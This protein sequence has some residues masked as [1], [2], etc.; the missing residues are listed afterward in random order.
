LRKLRKN[1]GMTGADVAKAL[2]ISGS[3]IS[4]VETSE[5]GIYLDDIE[6]LLD[7]YN[8]TRA[9]R[10]ELLDLARHA[11]E[12]GL[13]RM[14]NAHLPEEWQAWLDFED[15]ASRILNYEPFM[16]PGLLQTPEYSRAIIKATGHGMSNAEVDALVTSRMARQGL[17]SRTKPLIL[18]VILE[19]SVL[20]RM[21]GDPAAQ[22]RQ[23]RH[24]ADMAEL[25]NITV[26]VAPTSAGLHSGLNGPFVILEYDEEAS[27]V[28][29]ENKIANI[30]LDEEEQIQVFEATWADL[31]QL[32]YSPDETVEY[33]RSKT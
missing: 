28:L 1:T 26:R 22:R 23:I 24:L 13:T 4:R 19:E 17:L 11:E 31:R 29:L 10:A 32:A 3:K 2:D 7:F 25:P 20:E 14:N 16:I 5:S 8:V 21:F 15:E 9:L 12:R 6:K 27:L 18:D 33:L 30:F